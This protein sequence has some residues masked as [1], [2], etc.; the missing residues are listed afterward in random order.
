MAG[1][2]VGCCIGQS[3]ALEGARIVSGR[4]H[5]LHVHGQIFEVP[6]G[7]GMTQA[8]GQDSA[9]TFATRHQAKQFGHAVGIAVIDSEDD[10]A[11]AHGLD[12]ESTQITRGDGIH[13]QPVAQIVEIDDLLDGI[14]HA[15]PAECVDGLVFRTLYL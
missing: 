4:F 9:D 8:L 13:S 1:P 11:P 7:S 10:L 6:P 14:D 5:A 3:H 12:G 2:P 15:K